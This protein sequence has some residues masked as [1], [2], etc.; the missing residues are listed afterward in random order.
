[1]TY[2]DT[3][4]PFG[5]RLGRPGQPDTVAVPTGARA[6]GVD[7]CLFPTDGPEIRLPLGHQL[8][9]TWWEVLPPGCVRP[10]T[11]YGLRVDGPGHNPAKL[12]QEIGRAHV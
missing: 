11:R 1:M 8:G 2:S 5:L 6:T 9:R 7:L 4:P 3:P 10:G 12:L